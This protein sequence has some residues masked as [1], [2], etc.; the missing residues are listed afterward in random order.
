MCVPCRLI[1]TEGPIFIL[2][3][4]VRKQKFSNFPKVEELGSKSLNLY[5]GQYVS[6]YVKK[7]INATLH[8]SSYRLNIVKKRTPTL[9]ASYIR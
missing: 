1:L 4:Q 7:L 9:V 3:S 2:I 5:P 6:S 8:L